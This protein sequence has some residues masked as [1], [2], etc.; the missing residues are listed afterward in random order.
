MEREGRR[1]YEELAFVKESFMEMNT[2]LFAKFNKW[3][4]PDGENVVF[5]Q[6]F[7]EKT[8]SRI[9]KEKP[10]SMDAFQFI[11]GSTTIAIVMRLSKVAAKW[12]DAIGEIDT[13]ETALKNLP[14]S[15]EHERN[16]KLL[17]DHVAHI[18]NVSMLFRSNL[19]DRAIDIVLSEY[20]LKFSELAFEM[21]ELYSEVMKIHSKYMNI[22]KKEASRIPDIKASVS[23]RNPQARE[24]EGA[25]DIVL[26]QGDTSQDALRTWA[27][28]F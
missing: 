17:V 18:H 9:E 14:L 19:V 27:E 12:K 3:M 1:Y 28:Y 21:R 8:R 13:L 2:P 25:E 11:P 4:A 15:R 6:T 26:E 16:R 24:I 22:L 10:G 7:I 5:L 23:R 20:D